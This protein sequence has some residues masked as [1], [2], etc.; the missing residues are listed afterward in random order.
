LPE[1]EL[2]RIQNEAHL[3]RAQQVHR[4]DL[5]L[6][7]QAAESVIRNELPEVAK[8]FPKETIIRRFA[9]KRE[10]GTLRAVTDFRDVGKLVKAADDNLVS[11]ATIVAATKELIEH[12]EEN[13]KQVFNRLASRAYEQQAIARKAEILNDNLRSLSAGPNEELAEVLLKALHALR[14]TIDNVLGGR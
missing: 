4:E 5:Y 6:E 8:D 14:A 13:P 9:E 7:I 1:E 10:K 12:V 11:R 2:D 3:D